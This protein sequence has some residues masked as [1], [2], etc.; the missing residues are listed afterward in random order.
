[1]VDTSTATAITYDQKAKFA[2]IVLGYF[3]N[4]MIDSFGDLWKLNL[5]ET[6]RRALEKDKLYVDLLGDAAYRWTLNGMS[7]RRMREAVER[8]AS[9][10]EDEN[11]ATIPPMSYFITAFQQEMTEFDISII[12][13]VGYEIFED[14]VN[15][16]NKV[17]DRIVQVV[18][19]VGTSI[20]NTVENLGDAV[21]NTSEGLG[22]ITKYLPMIIV[23]II[24]TIL[25]TLFKIGSNSKIGKI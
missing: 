11:S 20:G 22:T 5:Q 4:E 24:V 25:A 17:N 12:S 8:V 18:G 3:V 9:R 19:S 6:E 21:E 15:A 10:L 2:R 13:G 1:M 14:I 16:G 23:G 7:P